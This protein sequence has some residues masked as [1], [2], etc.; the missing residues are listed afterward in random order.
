MPRPGDTA[1]A[2][3]KAAS[4]NIGKAAFVIVSPCKDRIGIARRSAQECR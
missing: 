1:A 4:I 3:A 2:S